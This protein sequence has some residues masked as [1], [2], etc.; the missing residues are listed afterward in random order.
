MISLRHVETI[1]INTL[2]FDFDGTLA[3]TLAFT[4]NSALEINRKLKLLDSEKVNVEKF[5]STD[6]KAFFKDLEI[7]NFKLFWFLLKYQMRLSKEIDN[8]KTFEN[9]PLVLSELKDSSVKIGIVTSNSKKNVRKFLL[10]NDLEYFDFIYTSINYFQ[11]GKLLKK[12][13]KKHKLD[14]SKVIYVGDEI[15]DIK[16]AKEAGVKVASVTWGYNFESLLSTHNPDFI[17]NRPEELLNLVK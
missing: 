1:N 10:N 11:K 4:I 6:S 9:L 3:D 15:R 16:A 17:I 7:S 13:I 14:K 8:I 5:R 2:I 12:T